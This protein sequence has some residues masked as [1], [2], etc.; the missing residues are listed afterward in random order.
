MIAD[1]PILENVK[2]SDAGKIQA[3]W[4]AYH[5][6]GAEDRDKLDSEMGSKSGQRLLGITGSETGKCFYLAAGRNLRWQYGSGALFG[7]QQGQELIQQ[8]KALVG[9]KCCGRC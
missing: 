8:A 3:A 9:K 5:A 4:D 7:I 6:L 1:L 2:A